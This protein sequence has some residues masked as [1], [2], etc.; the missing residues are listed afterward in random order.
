MDLSAEIPDCILCTNGRGYQ[1]RGLM[2]DK[3]VLDVVARF[4]G[5]NSLAAYRIHEPD[6][7]LFTNGT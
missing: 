3:E 4:K 5:T 2:S 1:Y 7:L 6:P